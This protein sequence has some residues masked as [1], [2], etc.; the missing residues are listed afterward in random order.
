MDDERIIAK[1]RNARN[2]DKFARLWSGDTSGYA[3]NADAVAALV[4]MVA[5][6][7]G[8]DATSE[9]IERIVS[10]SALGSVPDWNEDAQ[11][12]RRTIAKGIKNHP[13]RRRGF[14]VVWKSSFEG[15]GIFQVFKNFPVIRRKFRLHF[16]F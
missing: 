7:A 14:F 11:F 5:Y 4:R 2:G 12:R 9:Q 3:C 6:W 8:A 16:Q 10:Q 15:P 13:G 1:A